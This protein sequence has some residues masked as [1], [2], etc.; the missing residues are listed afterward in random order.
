METFKVEI[1]EF[2]SRIVDIEANSIDEAL[3]KVNQS[4]LNQEIILDY[5]DFISNQI[6]A[7]Q[8]QR[9]IDFDILSNGD[10]FYM[11]NGKRITFWGKDIETRISIIEN[12]VY[13]FISENDIPDNEPCEFNDDIDYRL[14]LM[15]YSKNE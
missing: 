2:L 1:K 7:F 5:N 10:N 8:Q 4:Y 9:L 13:L 6:E 15:L 3:D 14:F 11:I 12:D